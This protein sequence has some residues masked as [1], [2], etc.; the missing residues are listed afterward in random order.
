MRPE[1]EEVRGVMGEVTTKRTGG[2]MR[3]Q[4]LQKKKCFKAI[5]S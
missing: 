3:L 4:R 2:I 5:G 1:V